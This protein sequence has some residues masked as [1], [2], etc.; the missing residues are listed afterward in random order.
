MRNA[1]GKNS[2]VRRM[3][4]KN[5]NVRKLGK[6]KLSAGKKIV[7]VKN[8]LLIRHYKPTFEQT[9]PSVSSFSSPIAS[10]SLN[11]PFPQLT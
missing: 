7:S 6:R 8:F 11:K 3:I 4:E 10:T 2:K 5:E 9:L 1:K